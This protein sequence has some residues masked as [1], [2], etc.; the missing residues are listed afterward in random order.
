MIPSARIAGCE[1]L[2]HLAGEPVFGGLLTRSRRDRIYT[3]RIDSTRALVES[4]GRLPAA[5][6]PKVLVC[7][8]AVGSRVVRP[9]RTV[10][11]ASASW[12]LTDSATL[13][14]RHSSS[15]L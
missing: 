12:V 2:V 1:A 10:L 7:A 13:D 9:A 6:R 11:A 15:F 5:E 14:V 3:S 4:I 8:A